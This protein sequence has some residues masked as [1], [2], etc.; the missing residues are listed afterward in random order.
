VAPTPSIKVLKT[1][2]YRGAPKVWSNRYHFTGGTPADAAHWTTLSDAITTAERLCYQTG[3]ST[4][5]QTIGYAAGSDVPVFTKAYSLTPTQTFTNWQEVP[6]D[7]T[8]LMRYATTARTPKNHPVY[9][10]N[11]YH[12]VGNATGGAA[13]TL[14]PAQRSALGTYA[15]AWLSGFSDGT[16]TYVRAGPNGAT[17]VGIANDTQITHRDFPR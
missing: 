6:G 14:N 5:I 11:Y 13:D 2:T 9:L 1:F 16:L 4:I 10:F 7:C 15:A 8:A 12:G 3:T 17:A